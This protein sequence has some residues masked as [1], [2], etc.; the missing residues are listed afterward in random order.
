MEPKDLDPVRNLLKSIQKGAKQESQKW[1]G[2][3]RYSLA[4]K[5]FVCSH[6]GNNLFHKSLG[7]TNTRMATLMGLDFLDTQMTILT[8]SECG[9]LAWLNQKPEKKD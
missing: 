6:C 7:Q 3:F 4:N 1:L 8:C 2:P 9:L 5:D